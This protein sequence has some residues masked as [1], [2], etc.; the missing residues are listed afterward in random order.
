MWEDEPELHP[1]ARETFRH[2]VV[3]GI[4]LLRG[5]IRDIPL[6]R[7]IQHG[8]LGRP[9]R[10]KYRVLDSIGR[11]W[12]RV[13]GQFSIRGWLK[14]IFDAID[15]IL[16]CVIDAAGGAGGLIKEFKDASAALVKTTEQVEHGG[17]ERGTSIKL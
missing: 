2:D 9:V 3:E 16:N 17:E 12:D 1:L 13:R 6:E 7:L 8:L 15:A 14:R 10:F 5:T 4:H 11:Q